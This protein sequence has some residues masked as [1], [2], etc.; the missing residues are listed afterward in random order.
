MGKNINRED[1]KVMR[2]LTVNVPIYIINML[3]HVVYKGMF[4]SRS[5]LIRQLIIR[6]LPILIDEIK[7]LN[8]LIESGRV[9]DIKKLFNEKGYYLSNTMRPTRKY[10]EN[11]IG[12]P[13]WERDIEDNHEIYINKKDPNIIRFKDDDG[14][15]KEWKIKPQRDINE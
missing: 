12:N 9:L 15:I 8:Y 1:D 7:E 5:E 11:P 3:D 13:F 14:I 10:R 6:E 2:V 4:P